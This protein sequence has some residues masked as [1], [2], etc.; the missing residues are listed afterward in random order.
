LNKR[1]LK[2][3]FRCWETKGKMFLARKRGDQIRMNKVSLIVYSAKEL[4]STK[5][6][7]TKFLGVEP[8][9]DQ[10]Y[11]VGYRVGD[12]EIGLDP[13]SQNPGSVTYIDVADIK[14]SLQEIIALGGTVQQD[15]KD[16]ANGL[17]VASVKDKDGNI[18]GF[19][20]KPQ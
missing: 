20:Q 10:P 1:L 6:I 17:L 11:Y 7:F 3:R 15:V 8:Y 19:R 16:V 5:Q 4:A 9:V 12:M 13:N 2:R 18:L 14:S